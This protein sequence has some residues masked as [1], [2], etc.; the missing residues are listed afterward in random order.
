MSYI[1][2]LQAYKHKTY[3]AH[4]STEHTEKDWL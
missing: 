1:H 3:V 4:D 2:N